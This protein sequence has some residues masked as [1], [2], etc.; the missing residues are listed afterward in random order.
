MTET[1]LFCLFLDGVVREGISEERTL[2]LRT[3]S[4]G[5]SHVKGREIIL[6]RGEACAK[7]PRREQVG[8]LNTE[9]R[10]PG[11]SVLKEE[12]QWGQ[13]QQGKQGDE[14]GLGGRGQKRGSFSM[15]GGKPSEAC[16]HLRT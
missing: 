1:D 4:E 2:D 11:P 7:G 8:L 9:S 6:S 13:S 10:Q 5:I 12:E 16:E 15:N 3:E 14:A